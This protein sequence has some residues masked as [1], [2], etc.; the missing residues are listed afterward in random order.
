M[1]TMRIEVVRLSYRSYILGT[2][3]R[4]SL[5]KCYSIILNFLMLFVLA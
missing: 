5:F 4:V 2:Y 1:I 3:L